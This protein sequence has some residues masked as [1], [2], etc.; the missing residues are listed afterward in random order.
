MGVVGAMRL[1]AFGTLGALVVVLPTVALSETTPVTETIK[2]ENLGIYTHY[3][4]PSEVQAQAGASVQISNPTEVAH[5]VE[6]IDPP[7]GEAPSC[8]KSVPV[9]DT[10][11][12]SGKN[13]S[14]S[15][16]FAKPGV[17]VFYCT[18]HG[19]AMRGQIT[20][21]SPAPG[22]PASTSTTPATSTPT[23]VAGGGASP[24]GETGSS[25]TSHTP[26]SL[27][28]GPLRRALELRGAPHGA[29]I[30]ATLR[31][32]VAAA[33]A[34]LA[35]NVTAPQAALT[36]TSGNSSLQIGHYARSSLHAGI[37]SFSI[38]LNAL[39]RRALRKRAHLT[40][41][42]R[43]LL[44]PAHGPVLSLLRSLTLHR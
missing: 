42:I 31:L 35:V 21:G 37:V 17:Y 10:E 39:A 25:P 12:A 26:A 5:G 3:W 36:G 32:S 13:W 11:A 41:A 27:L 34:H 24:P 44:K 1:A 14:G 28:A 33:G 18:V 22:T 23:G 19:P 43:L 2:A 16:T 6:W 7:G 38:H 9:G 29:I 40:I 20:V 15:C 4:T 8:E 30:H